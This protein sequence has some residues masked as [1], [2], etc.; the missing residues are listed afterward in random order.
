[1]EV[2]SRGVNLTALGLIPSTTAPA[3]RKT[4]TPTLSAESEAGFQAKVIKLAKLCKWA[5]YHTY[6]SDKSV[7]GFPDL[8]L[9]RG[10]RL[11]VVELK[12]GRNKPTTE[13]A[14]WLE[15]FRGVCEEV[16]VWYP[17]DWPMI[18]K[19]LAK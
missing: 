17:S 2:T 12:V 1:M 6:R 18:E 8:I 9:V 5:S 15:L 10:S 16:F 19:T 3:T 13:Q 11:V 7:P 14:A 4:K